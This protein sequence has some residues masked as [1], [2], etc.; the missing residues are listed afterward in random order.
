MTDWVELLV[1]YDETEV[2][3]IKNILD[4]EGIDTV[5][6]SLKIRPYPVSI[7]KIGEIRVL[8]PKDR[9]SDAEKLLNI[10]KENPEHNGS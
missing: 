6:N 2:Q 3:I 4:S 5:I 8:V 7:G 10:M 9:L 1:T